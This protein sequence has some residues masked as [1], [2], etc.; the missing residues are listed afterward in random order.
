ME[1]LTSRGRGRALCTGWVWRL[2]SL[3]SVR[4]C[5][6]RVQGCGGDKQREG[7]ESGNQMEADQRREDTMSC[8]HKIMWL[9]II[10]AILECIHV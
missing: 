5:G 6:M 9:I 3:S 4:M 7:R 8:L 1:V 2:H 10:P